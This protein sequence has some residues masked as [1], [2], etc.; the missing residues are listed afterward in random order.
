MHKVFGQDRPKLSATYGAIQDYL[1]IIIDWSNDSRV[2]FTMCNFLRDILEEASSNFNGENTTPTTKSLF[3][4]G[5][6]SL[7]NEEL[8]GQFH[9]I[10]AR[11]L[12]A[13]KR[14]RP[15]I[16]VAVAFLCKRI[17][18]PNIGD[19]NK[20]KRLA[21]NVRATIHIPL[22]LGYDKSGCLV[23]S[24]DAAFA[25]YTIMKSHTGYCLTLGN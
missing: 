2:R 18:K 6:V 19:W 11:F 15:D 9:R 12:Y 25:V 8:A 3:Q 23:W 20:L 1:G 21:R 24:I 5:D 10:V 14:A 16:E 7:L 4:V 22:L 17:K 13:A